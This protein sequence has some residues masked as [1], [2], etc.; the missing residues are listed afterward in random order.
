MLPK[1]RNQLSSADPI[2]QKNNKKITLT[3]TSHYRHS[4][5]TINRKYDLFKEQGIERT[6]Y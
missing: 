5:C 1:T 6:I 2:V 4:Q 3:F